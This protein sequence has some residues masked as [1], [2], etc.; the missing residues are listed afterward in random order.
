MHR[1]PTRRGLAKLAYE[2]VGMRMPPNRAFGG[3]QLQ[4]DVRARETVAP[5]PKAPVS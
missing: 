1:Y 2:P 4:P 5:V 3:R